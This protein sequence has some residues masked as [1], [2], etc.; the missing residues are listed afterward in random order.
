MSGLRLEFKE[1]YPVYRGLRVPLWEKGKPV[2]V[3]RVTDED[4]K[5]FH[6][7]L[8]RLRAFLEALVKYWRQK[9]RLGDEEL[10][11]RVAD[12]IA[13]FFKAPLFIEAVPVAP[14]PLKAFAYTLLLPR[15]DER[16]LYKF[17]EALARAMDPSVIELLA[18]LFD[19]RTSELVFD[20][21]VKFPA[22][23]RP[24]RN[25][26]SLVSH[27]LLTS[28]LAWAIETLR[29]SDR[30][31]V[32]VVR[33]ASMLHDLGKVVDPERH[34][35]ASAELSR[36]LLEGLLP[37]GTIQTIVTTIREHH[38]VESS[39]QRA[40]RLAA[41]ADRLDELVNKILGKEIN[42]IINALGAARDE[43]E[44]WRKAYQRLDE[45]KAKGLVSEDPIYELTERFLMELE[46]SLSEVMGRK[47]EPEEVG[48][49]LVEASLVLMDFA[50]VQDFVYRSQEI[51]IVSAA[52]Y[53]VDLAV[54]THLLS[55]LR[56]SGFPVPPEA[57]IYSGGG[58]ILLLL[59]AGWVEGV[60]K[61]VGEYEDSTGLTIHVAATPF[62][63][64]YLRVS[65]LLGQALAYSKYT[66]KLKDK[67]DSKPVGKLCSFC[68][69][70]PATEKVETP[71]GERE[72][73]S[74][75][76]RL[77]EL[78]SRIHFKVKWE[79]EI[80]VAKDRF[81]PKGA[82][83]ANWDEVSRWII[84]II[85]GHDLDE[86]REHAV[87]QRDYAA[88]KFD[89]N[90]IGSFMLASLSFADAVERS[91]RIDV[92]MK[93][94]YLRALEALYEGVKAAD[95]DDEARKVVSQVYLG[96]VYMGGD[97]GLLLAPSWTAPIIAHFIVEEF[98]RQLGLARGLSVAVAAGPARM[99]V[100]SLIDCSNE[101]LKLCKDVTRERGG[102][103]LA[104][105]V[106][107]SGSPSG[108]TARERILS[109][110][111]RAAR[112]ALRLSDAQVGVRR[113]ARR[114]DS[115]QPY[116]VPL[117]YTP[118]EAWSTLFRPVLGLGGNWSHEASF[119]LHKDALMK[120]YLA[121]RPKES[122]VTRD[123][124]ALRNAL[125]RAWNQVSDS[126]YWREKL[127]IY[128][129]R[130]V[131]RMEERE[132]A[133]AYARLTR[134]LE[135]TVLGPAGAAPLADVLVLIKLLRGGV[136]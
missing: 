99:S 117:G 129:L 38:L 20:L 120:A 5:E 23:T 88:V 45:L 53:L 21:W 28:A 116:L 37:E 70:A 40:D 81:S 43:W 14:T 85:A 61:R 131:G 80:S 76:K 122:E 114:S 36:Q 112:A 72:A 65:R 132:A 47:E 133:E 33:L 79:S 113:A 26:S 35:E 63:S 130:Q 89:G 78:G 57:V 73:C 126:Q 15:P 134:L 1:P 6:E 9:L 100:W 50:S 115:L 68:Y 111:D 16:D 58:V 103:A 46:K 10:L 102:G 107:E 82:F 119:Q 90:M 101:L 77:Y 84:E 109:L 13:I 32:A 124:K 92:A 4:R 60:K 31:R 66:V 27:L 69:A 11:E 42:A 106:Y 93:R 125:M 62:S 29:G 86:I 98:G 121:S 24:G 105:D 123:L 74:L 127:L 136:Q 55:F 67:P 18:P 12:A 51:R 87:V 8:Y 59:P 128:S 19:P 49:R 3:R 91:F 56:A 97:D 48:E 17:A 83:D 34:Y 54:H 52:S 30:E 75:C 71:E 22:D 44:F 7:T 94:A 108:T 41:A 39:L 135:A 2:R 96:T 64:N 25:V 104:F 118:P 110:S 95:G